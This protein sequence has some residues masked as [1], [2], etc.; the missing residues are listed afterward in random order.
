MISLL[1]EI[2]NMVIIGR[3]DIPFRQVWSDCL[4]AGVGKA[5]V[6][7]ATDLLVA[8][9][10]GGVL[11]AQVVGAMARATGTDLD[12]QAGGVCAAPFDAALVVWA[13]EAVGDEG[14]GE[15]DDGGAAGD[16]P[17]S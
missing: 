9:L 6:F 10:A 3:K 17:G 1:A 2:A 4:L 11:V 16:R 14:R 12:V 8:G 15:F 5:D 7:G 13:G